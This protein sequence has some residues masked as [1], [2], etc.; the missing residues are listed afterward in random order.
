[1]THSIRALVVAVFALSAA[2]LS[3]AASAA[4]FDQNAIAVRGYDVVAYFDQGE[5]QAGDNG[6]F[7]VH[8]GLTYLF[9]NNEH[10]EAF[11]ANPERYVPAYGGYCAMGV[12]LGYKLPIDPE[13]WYIENE[14]LYLNVSKTVQKTWLKDVPGNITKADSNWPKIKDISPADFN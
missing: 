14:R 4:E 9:A 1:M 13:A 11:N 12:A 8:N 7:A 10:R 5:A 6:F 3:Q 2:A